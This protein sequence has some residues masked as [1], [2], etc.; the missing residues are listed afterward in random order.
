MEKSV[1]I[2][3]LLLVGCATIRN[4]QI[5]TTNDPINFLASKEVIKE[6]ECLV[7]N[8]GAQVNLP[9]VFYRGENERVLYVAV[10]HPRTAILL[11]IR[12]MV[13]GGAQSVVWERK[14]TVIVHLTASI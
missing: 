12:R 13:Q 1:L 8:E 9:C 7:N 4:A 6:G 14:S 11:T 10:Y 2:L 5:V 3:V